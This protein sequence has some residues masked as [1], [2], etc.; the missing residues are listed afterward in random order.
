MTYEDFNFLYIKFTG[1]TNGIKLT[2]TV[3]SD[4]QEIKKFLELAIKL[5]EDGLIEQS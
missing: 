1:N 4:G 5:Y 2:D 3:H